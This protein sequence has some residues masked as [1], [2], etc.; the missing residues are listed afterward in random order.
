MLAIFVKQN[1]VS[2]QLTAPKYKFHT[3]IKLAQVCLGGGSPDASSLSGW[4]R[5]LSVG[6]SAVLDLA[7]M[8]FL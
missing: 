3:Y 1:F 6:F 2:T 8:G 4:S 5:P 7:H